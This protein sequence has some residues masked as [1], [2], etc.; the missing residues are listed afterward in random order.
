VLNYSNE[1]I[2]EEE[3]YEQEQTNGRWSWCSWCWPNRSV[4]DSS[5]VY[6][7]EKLRLK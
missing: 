1:E 4:E 3:V 7:R 2:I 5:Y 6:P